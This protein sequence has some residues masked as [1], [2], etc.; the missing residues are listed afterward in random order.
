M[1]PSARLPAAGNQPPLS[2]SQDDDD[3]V[4]TPTKG[5]TNE[6]RGST[7]E[8]KTLKFRFPLTKYGSN[9]NVNPL[10]LHAHWMHEVLTAFGDGVKFFDNSNRKIG[11]IDLLSITQESQEHQFSVHTTQT[12]NRRKD[13]VQGKTHE[14]QQYPN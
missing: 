10:V 5:E 14:A 8:E 7:V 11:K 4:V 1:D 6:S 2:S 3:T 12:S 13:D 9:G